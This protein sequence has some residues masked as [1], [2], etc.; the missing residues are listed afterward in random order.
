MCR[1]TQDRDIGKRAHLNE[2]NVR[3]LPASM[4]ELVWDYGALN[5][6]QEN[7]YIKAKLELWSED[8]CRTTAL[9][10]QTRGL[11]YQKS[12]PQIASD[13]FRQAL[14]LTL[15][16]LTTFTNLMTLMNLVILITLGC[17]WAAESG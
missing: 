9:E 7:D 13:W 15:I 5:K 14:W 8:L 12:Q 6:E 10:Y 4:M 11:R 17:W 16:T 3:R 1:V 2:Y